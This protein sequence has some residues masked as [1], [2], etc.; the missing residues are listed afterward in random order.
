[1]KMSP[2]TM[3]CDLSVVSLAGKVITMETR[4]TW[5]IVLKKNVCSRLQPWL[6]VDRIPHLLALG[7]RL[8]PTCLA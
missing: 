7:T 1:M 8:A 6:H 3:L 4:Q 2:A 5:R